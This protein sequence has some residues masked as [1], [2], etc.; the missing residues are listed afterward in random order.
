MIKNILFT[1]CPNSLSQVLLGLVPS[2]T[3]GGRN[4]HRGRT[5]A[6]LPYEGAGPS[7]V[8][9]RI[10][11]LVDGICVGATL[12]PLYW[13]PQRQ[14]AVLAANITDVVERIRHVY[15]GTV[16]SRLKR[17]AAKRPRGAQ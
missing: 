6:L 5:T 17:V 15:D 9:D 3:G 11:V 8:A 13:P 12:D 14:R 7:E 1:L 4:V 2:S 16:Q 10:I